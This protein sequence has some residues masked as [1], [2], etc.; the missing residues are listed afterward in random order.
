[1]EARAASGERGRGKKERKERKEKWG[2]MPE[3]KMSEEKG[4]RKG[5]GKQTERR[6]RARVIDA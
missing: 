2:E 1:M 5:S 4:E 3:G 6:R